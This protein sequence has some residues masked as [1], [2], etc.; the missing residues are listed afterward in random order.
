MSASYYLTTLFKNCVPR[1]Q[2]QRDQ[3]LS[4]KGV[5]CETNFCHGCPMRLCHQRYY[6][7]FYLF[8]GSLSQDY[9]QKILLSLSTRIESTHR[10]FEKRRLFLAYCLFVSLICKELRDGLEGTQPFVVMDT[11]HTVVRILTKPEGKEREGVLKELFAP[12]CDV[13]LTICQA[14]LEACP[15]VHMTLLVPQNTLI[16][17]TVH[18][19]INPSCFLALFFT[20]RS[21]RSTCI[22]LLL[23]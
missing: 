14:T 6:E 5:A 15:K 8:F 17:F 3:T 20:C 12:C 1:R 23:H 13:L 16:S 11:I 19:Y 9:I 18:K 4:V 21:W 2:L 22:P 7:T 10:P